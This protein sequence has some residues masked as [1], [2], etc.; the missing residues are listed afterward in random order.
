M[1]LAESTLISKVTII[2]TRSTT[3]AFF[4]SSP[5][6]LLALS[7]PLFFPIVSVILELIGPKKNVLY[8]ELSQMTLRDTAYTNPTLKF[9]NYNLRF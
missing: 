4:S 3:I 8:N 7:F 6:F 5:F 1:D 9:L 2:K